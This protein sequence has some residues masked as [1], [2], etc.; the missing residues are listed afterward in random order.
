MALY[1]T[2]VLIGAITLFVIF[3]VS[4]YVLA[5][6]GGVTIDSPPQGRPVPDRDLDE[7]SRRW[8]TH[9]GSLEEPARA[10][11]GEGIPTWKRHMQATES[12]Q[13]SVY[14]SRP[15]APFSGDHWDPYDESQ[16]A[17][18]R[19][20]AARRKPRPHR[21]AS[22]AEP[23]WSSRLDDDPYELLGVSRVASTEEIEQA[24]R[25]RVSVIHPDKFHGD[26]ERRQEAT[27]T[28]KQLNAAMRRVR[29]RKRPA[30][31]SDSVM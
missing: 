2:V 22:T 30:P 1:V 16:S 5:R 7:T 3:V 6:L 20:Q 25:R 13:P 4:Q 29:E 11:S 27:E 9:V 21:V 24:Y 15:A 23:D 28:L 26:P 19:A 12:P 31:D 18:S 17:A 10:A 14:R 8:S